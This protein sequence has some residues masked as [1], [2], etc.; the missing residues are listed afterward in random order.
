MLQ[1]QDTNKR[2]SMIAVTLDE[3]VPQDHLV[4]KVDAAIDF[5]SSM[6]W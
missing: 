5:Y 4:R 1:R 3:L 6:I 2:H